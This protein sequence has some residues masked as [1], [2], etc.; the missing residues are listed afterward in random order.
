MIVQALHDIQHEFGYL[1]ADELRALSER[2][3]QPLHR[4]HEVASFFPHY[5]LKPPPQ[6]RVE[7]CCDMACH[8][9]GGDDYLRKFTKLAEELDGDK[10]SVRRKSCLGRCD[11]PP[12]VSINDQVYWGKTNDEIKEM[13]RMAVAGR[14]L[15]KQQIATAKPDW[16]IDLYHGRGHYD[17][18]RQCAEA[19]Q[20][21]AVPDLIK[22]RIKLGNRIL[23]KLG[24][25][26]ESADGKKKPEEGNLR[27]MG[28]AGADT[29]EKWETARNGKFRSD[30]LFE[31]CQLGRAEWSQ[32]QD[33]RT[34]EL[35][36]LW[37]DDCATLS[38]DK[39]VVCNGDESEPGTFKDRDLVLFAPHLLVEGMVIA[40]L[41]IGAKQGYIF[42]R[43]EYQDQIAALK[44]EIRRAEA[45]HY[46]GKNILETGLSFPVQ[47]LESPGGYICG[48]ESALLETIEDRR[49]EPRE[50]PPLM[51][52]EGLYG[53][54]TVVNNVET[55]CWVPAMILNAHGWYRD[56]GKNG[57]KGARFV[58]ISG[59]V[60]KPG[61]Y[62]VPF[63][64]T[65]S[66]LIET[67]GGMSGGRK[68]KAI[69]PSGPSGGFLPAMLELKRLKPEFIE[70]LRKRG[71]V[72]EADQHLDILDLQL[73]W[74]LLKPDFDLGGL[75]RL[76][77][78]R[79][80]ADRGPELR[81]VLPQRVVRQMRPLP[82]RHAENGGNASRPARRQAESQGDAGYAQG[83]GRRDVHGIDL[84][85]GEDRRQAVYFGVALFS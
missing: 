55:L 85:L 12:A 78:R 72:R 73:D 53:K 36:Q 24:R 22:R 29:R 27:G 81:R 26:I 48:E 46:C 23:D 45:E 64:Q 65:V 80:H 41:V 47:V 42:I 31:I 25:Q 4:L 62:E 84:R 33:K 60:A 28:G 44:A 21:D 56:L 13:I 30:K 70:R 79:R 17:A 74:D 83:A 51:Q 5:R 43:H 40:G 82:H 14:P 19:W 69:A 35:K 76:W 8:L 2:I 59:H 38:D 49:A 7:V 6:V 37:H 1:P 67:A 75:R 61:V 34:E 39:Y 16:Q 66:E 58:S 68:L 20:A 18:I 32:T 50:K 9:A 71:V 77:R 3:N 54:P 10:V 63:G 15:P 11:G 57:G 52:M